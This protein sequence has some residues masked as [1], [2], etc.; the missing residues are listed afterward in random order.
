MRAFTE[1]K[2]VDL[3]VPA[4]KN[5]ALTKEC[6]D[7]ILTNIPEISE[8]DPRLVIV[9]DSPD[10][11]ECTKLLKS[12]QAKNIILITN[13]VNL[14]FVKSVNKALE[15]SIADRR[16]VILINSDTVTFK[17]TLIELLRVSEIDPQIA[18]VSPRSNN[19]SI[20]S[21]P[22][23]LPGTLLDPDSAYAR[24]K[25]ISVLMP[26]FH[27]TP[28]AV[29]FYLYI[30]WDAIANLGL[31]RQDFGVGYEEENDLILR[32]SKVGYRSCM[33]N[34]SYA[35]HHGSASFSL[36]SID[37]SSHKQNNLG[38][39]V[40]LHPEFIPLVQRYENSPHFRAE[41]QLSA[42]SV[43]PGEKIPL[44]IDLSSLGLYNNGTSEMAVGV[45][46]AWNNLRTSRFSVFIHCNKAVAKFHGLNNLENIGVVEGLDEET[47]CISVRLGQPFDQHHVNCLETLAPI[48]IYGMLDT[49]AED[50]GYLSASQQLESLW[51]YVARHA[52][53]IFYISDFSKQTFINRF[54]A[55]KNQPDY[56]SLLPNTV[57]CYPKG[58][59][60]KSASHVLVLGNHFA[61]KHSDELGLFI[62]KKYP[63]NLVVFGAENSMKAN[64]KSYK[65][66]DID[67][68]VV[69]RIFDSSSVVV[70]PSFV[71]GFGLGFMHALS[72]GKPIVARDIPTTREILSTFESYSGIYLFDDKETFDVALKAALNEKQSVAKN[73]V[74]IDWNSWVSA[75]SSFCESTLTSD[76]VFNRLVSRL[77]AS[78]YLRQSLS[79][80]QA[81]SSPPVSNAT[82]QAQAD[83]QITPPTAPSQE[84]FL[85]KPG[86]LQSMT[87]NE[88][89]IRTILPLEGDDFIHAAFHILLDRKPDAAGLDNYRERLSCGVSKEEIILAISQ[90]P[91]SF[92]K[93]RKVKGMEFIASSPK[94]RKSGA[95]KLLERLSRKI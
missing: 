37:L 69:D 27:F 11:D 79:A 15:Q 14:G 71:E 92:N 6:I 48:N 42:F 21:L 90:S 59:N 74:S 82:P 64:F 20:C 1:R 75:F 10:D 4:Y 18:F 95:R 93:N 56:V 65:S 35:Y 12:Y 47:F 62:E 29:G 45:V 13:E 85:V 17:G 23:Q 2:S 38:K 41:K 52:S 76:D 50:C 57:D 40:K 73:K 25:K 5:A 24:W 44:V 34:H 7:S 9:N 3:I 70:L 89:D 83:D 43:L 77:R 78:D 72:R 60:S 30:K 86:T 58:A 53:G 63:L 51:D 94:P 32:C 8:Y 26:Q 33:A 91:E 87:T 22:H 28:T 55:A 39:M 36:T 54:P 16:N 80:R 84:T 19:A 61:H 49:I 68:T 31:L 66:G 67:Q 88:N 81:S 46:K